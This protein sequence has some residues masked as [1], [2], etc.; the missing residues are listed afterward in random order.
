MRKLT[1]TEFIT[2]DGVMEDPGGAEKF[3]LGGWA[4]KFQRGPEGDKFKMDEMLT[5]D[6]FLLGRVTYEGFAAAWPSRTGEFA[7][8]MNNMPKYIVSTTLKNPVWKNS[9]VIKENVAEEV[10]KLKAMPGRDILVAGSARLVNT[11]LE[12]DLVDE[13]RLMVYPVVLGKGKRLFTNGTA[14]HT[15]RLV[16]VKQVGEEGVITMIY[17]MVKK[18]QI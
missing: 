3:E 8:M 12:H 15:M 4:F 5:C 13:F 7:D 9:T 11:L 17:Q 10:A 16:E 2:L 14:D 6:A 1:V 18:Q